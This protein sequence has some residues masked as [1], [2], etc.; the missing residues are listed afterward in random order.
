MKL[1]VR[2]QPVEIDPPRKPLPAP[3]AHGSSG[4]LGSVQLR[5]ACLHPKVRV[6]STGDQGLSPAGAPRPAGPPRLSQVQ[7]GLGTHGCSDSRNVAPDLVARAWGGG[8][9][10]IAFSF[11][12]LNLV[13]ILYG[14]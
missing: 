6:R 2:N 12:F 4:A 13:C 5:G 14:I 11:C 9:A 7:A 10:G 1:R 8:A 3:R